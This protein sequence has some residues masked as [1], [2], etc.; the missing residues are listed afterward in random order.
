MATLTVFYPQSAGATFDA[1]YYREK[2][3]PLAGARWADA[4]M[5]GGEALI[6]RQAVGGGAPP[7]L[8]VGILHFDTDESLNAALTGEHAA[9]VI[10]DIANFTNVQPI[11]QISERAAPPA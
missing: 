9:E 7:F 8:A 2:H 6:G 5:V 11:L 1:A 3:L 4:G 10:A